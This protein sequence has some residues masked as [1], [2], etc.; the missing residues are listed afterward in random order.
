MSY[1]DSLARS[2]AFGGS[3]VLDEPMCPECDSTDVDISP[4]PRFDLMCCECGHKFNSED[5]E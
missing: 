3:S 4:S 1:L 5:C 2:I